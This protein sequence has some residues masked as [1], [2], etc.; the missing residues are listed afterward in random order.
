MLR[1]YMTE[2]LINIAADLIV[3]FIIKFIEKHNKKWSIRKPPAGTGGFDLKC[4]GFLQTYYITVNKKFQ[5]FF[6]NQ[7]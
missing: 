1:L 3:Y 5:Y 7:E 6:I 4:H 2:L